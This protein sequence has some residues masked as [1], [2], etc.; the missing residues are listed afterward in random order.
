MRHEDL[1]RSGMCRTLSVILFWAVVTGL[2]T[3]VVSPHLIAIT[4]PPSSG[5]QYSRRF[6]NEDR[7]E[8]WLAFVDESFGIHEINAT[9]FIP[10]TPKAPPGG[11]LVLSQTQW[12]TP[13]SDVSTLPC[14]S[15]LRHLLTVGAASNVVGANPKQVSEIAYGW[16]WLSMEADES[17]SPRFP[18][19]CVVGEARAVRMGT[20][21]IW[22]GLFLNA[23]IFTIGAIAILSLVQLVTQR[24]RKS[25]GR[26]SVCNYDL[27]ATLTTRCPE[28]G[29]IVVRE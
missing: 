16:P 6:W 15:A 25:L 23:L 28:C 20:S 11:A 17:N 8:T 4:V 13:L 26:C 1:N 21:V 9:R 27:R 18:D 2:L 12:S 24:V 22:P 10:P 3:A 5:V 29:T 14:W 7:H 19:W